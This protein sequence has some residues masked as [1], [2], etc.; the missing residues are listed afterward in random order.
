MPY[1]PPEVAAKAREMDLVAMSILVLN[2]RKIQCA[3]F[4]LPDWLLGFLGSAQKWAVI[5]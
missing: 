5:Q 3:F 4:E 1:I 2:L